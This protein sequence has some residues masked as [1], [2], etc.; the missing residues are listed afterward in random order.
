MFYHPLL[1]KVISKLKT[2]EELQY[3]HQEPK[4]G[5]FMSS[6]GMIMLIE[7]NGTPFIAET[8]DTITQ[9]PHT[10]TRT[11]DWLGTVKNW[12]ENAKISFNA[13]DTK[14]KNGFAIL[15]DLYVSE[16]NYK[17]VIDFIGPDV[18]IL[19]PEKCN[20]AIYFYNA[21]KS[22][23]A[24]LMTYNITPKTVK[25]VKWNVL[26]ASGTIIHTTSDIREAELFGLTVKLNEDRK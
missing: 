13:S 12:F 26:D 20:N 18:K 1:N 16:Q 22:R 21:D 8:W 24:L 19:T 6:D 17:T 10:I 11:L 14:F 15:G 5:M 9:T 4:T 3:V 2:R 23:Q 7:N 25:N